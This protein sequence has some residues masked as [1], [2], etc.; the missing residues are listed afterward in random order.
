MMSELVSLRMSL[1]QTGGELEWPLM[2]LW[3]HGGLCR[4]LMSQECFVYRT[5]SSP[6]LHGQ[7]PASRCQ[8]S[9][10][11]TLWFGQGRVS[12]YLRSYPKND[13]WIFD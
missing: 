3:S 13:H 8:Q 12:Q 11:P 5:Q 4:Q 6:C 2:V 1:R 9:P 10:V 7:A